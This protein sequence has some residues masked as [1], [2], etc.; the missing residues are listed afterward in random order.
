MA[1]LRAKQIK[2]AAAGDLLVGGQDGNGT[3]LTKGT[4]GQIL[5]I[6]AG[7]LAYANNTAADIAFSPLG[8]I[9]ATTVQAAIAE[10]ASDAADALTGAT[11]ALEAT[12]S[13]LQ[14]ELDA[15]Q[16][17]AGLAADGSYVADTTTEYLDA[18]TSLK[19]ADFI[20]DGKIKE[21]ADDL[22]E[23]AGG[24][25]GTSLASLQTEVDAIQTA[26]GLNADGT[27]DNTG[28]AG[29]THTAV[30]AATTVKGA[31]LAVDAALAA[32][33]TARAAAD[34]ALDARLDTAEGEIDTLQADVT[35]LEGDL[36]DEV[37]ARI[38]ADSALQAELDLTQA[39]VGTATSG[40]PV[41][42]ANGNYII[43]G[44]AEVPETS[45]GVGDAVPAVTPD[46]HHAA[47]GK[48]DAALKAE[49]IARGA[50]DTFI[51]AELDATQAGAGLAS[52]GAYE[53]PTTSNYL[54]T[55]TT[56]KGADLLLDAALKV[57]ADDLAALETAQGADLTALQTEVDLI[58]TGLGFGADG[59][60][61]AF[62]STNYVAAGD[63]V[64]AA[65]N[66]L[67]TQVKTNADD[68]VAANERIDALGAAF[69]Y[70]GVLGSGAFTAFAAGAD[71]ASATDLEGLAAGQKDAGDY[72]KVGGD[73]YFKMGE[74]GTPVFVKQNDGIVFNTLGGFDVIDN[75]NSNV[76]AGA[77][78]AVTGST[79]TGFTVALDGIVP[80][81]N[82]GT[83]VAELA[84]I[85]G[86]DSGDAADAIV[87]TG[88]TGAV[89]ADVT[90]GLDP[91]KV[92]FSTLAESGLPGAGQD[93]RFLRWN[94][95]TKTI[96]YVTAAQLGATVRVEE[97]FAPVTAANAEVTLANAPVGDIQVFINGVKLKKAGFSISGSTVTLVDS[98]NGYGI[99]TGDTL[100]V[101][102]S[103]AA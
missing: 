98:A 93:G 70:V 29:S 12:I 43:Q 10:V 17:G 92:K 87:I 6:V 79:D 18:A 95:T 41:F 24:G 25:T 57:V 74:A 68:I 4:D 23:L 91:S 67:D 38:A 103:R 2:L 97:D 11:D 52:T 42:Y 75:T 30:A 13:D 36:A 49:E 54:N 73:G 35:A 94:N 71:A 48:L 27:F 65:V 44:A 102:Y 82:G 61:P 20:L 31:I 85:V 58:E 76:L 39:T 37:A 15:T 55:A 9:E 63:T 16:T 22:A 66:K 72:Y 50:A 60:K 7:G 84:D 53:A 14:D 77:N 5:K 40:A 56:L 78:I 80:V 33:E 90:I 100:S 32:E 34:D 1:Q 86:A 83:G 51:Q 8:D 64:V 89:I 59:S 62:T 28:Y 99:E 46:T 21:L 19:N 26:V 47:I 101:S 88:G 45:E 3:I 69:N 96:E 81:A